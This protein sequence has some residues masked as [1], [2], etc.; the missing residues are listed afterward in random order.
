MSAS[1][2][3]TTIEQEA[4]LAKEFKE[5]VNAAMLEHVLPIFDEASK[6]GLSIG[7]NSITPV[8][9]FFRHQLVGLHIRKIY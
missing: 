8:E 2:T 1:E 4:A 5:R 6:K 3:P 9:P 7:W